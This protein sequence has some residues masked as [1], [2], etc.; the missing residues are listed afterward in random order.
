VS[1]QAIAWVLDEAPGVPARL[2]A[3]LI[4]IANH[5]DTYGKGAWPSQ[6]TMARQTRK[7]DRAVRADV[8]QLEELGLIV[9]GDQRIVLHI[10]S[11]RRPVVW[12][13]PMPP[14]PEAR[15][16]QPVI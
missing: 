16:R 2:L 12:D 15:F 13:L 11:D 14:R 1:V 10:R 5:A 8:L 9:R 6:A 7:S 4:V 3:T